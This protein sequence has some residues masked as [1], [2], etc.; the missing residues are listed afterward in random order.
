MNET[1]IRAKI[2]DQVVEYAKKEAEEFC[3][4][5]SDDAY[6][7]Y[8]SGVLQAMIK[9]ICQDLDEKGIERLKRIYLKEG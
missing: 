7:S 1:E 6:Y 5:Y 8:L 9:G 4:R 2:A 3:S